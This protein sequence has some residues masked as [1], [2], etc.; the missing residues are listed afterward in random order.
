MDLKPQPGLPVPARPGAPFEKAKSLPGAVFAWVRDNLFNTWYNTVLTG[1][2]LWVSYQ[3]GVGFARWAL[4][5]AQWEVVTVNLRLLLIGRFPGDQLWRLWLLLGVIALWSGLSWGVWGQAGRWVAVATVAGLATALVLPVTLAV[6]LGLA[7][8]IGLVVSGLFLGRRWR[9]PWHLGLLIGG[10][11]LTPV[12]GLLLLKGWPGLTLLPAVE[13][14][15]W[16]GLLLTI[17]LAVVGIVA[18][19]PLG[20]LLAL[21]RRSTLPV[22][23]GFSIAFVE[24]VRGVPLVTVLF[25]AQV[26]LP[27]F[28]PGDLRPDK[29]LRAMAGMVLFSAAYVAE[30]VRG[31]LQAVPRG[32]IEAAQALGLNSVLTTL[33]IV[34]P[35]ALR[36]VIPAIVGQLI[37]LF[38]DTSLVA[39]VGLIE[40]LGMAQSIL[41][42]PRFLGRY[43]EVYVF[44][45]VVYFVFSYAMSYASRRLEL[46]LGVGER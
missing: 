43:A 32:Q 44:V 17:I 12:V 15:A 38:K 41:A 1:I 26:M 27:L 3:L 21:G 30:N 42:Q 18:S 24:L 4:H 39:I 23:R 36:A 25:M 11:L 13:T 14:S 9:Q 7:V 34:L 33:L 19:F 8:Q 20:I 29:V 37:S 46:A 40:L 6:R 22:I 45:A 16:G 10:W 31:G 28:L 2:S 5:T 35:Q